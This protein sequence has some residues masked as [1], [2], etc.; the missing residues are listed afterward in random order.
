MGKD[1][2]ILLSMRGSPPL[3]SYVISIFHDCKPLLL[4]LRCDVKSRLPFEK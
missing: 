3:V 2:S 4:I 1:G